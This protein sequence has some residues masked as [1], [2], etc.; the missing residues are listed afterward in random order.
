MN[1]AEFLRKLQKSGPA[2][3]YLFAGSESYERERCRSALLDAALPADEREQGLIST[4]SMR[5]RSALCST[6]RSLCRCSQRGV[7]CG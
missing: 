5:Y 2:P 4:I 7:C 1:P 6:T 3:V